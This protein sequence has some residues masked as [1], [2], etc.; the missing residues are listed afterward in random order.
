MNRQLL[1]NDDR[2]NFPA[3]LFGVHFPFRVEPHIY[4]TAG[5]LSAEYHGG[6]WLMY[7][8]EN[9]GFYMAPDDDAFR[10]SAENGYEGTMSGDAF[11]LTVCLY[12]F[13]EL[14]FSDIPGFVEVCAGQYHRLREY[15][16]EHPEVAA[17]LRAID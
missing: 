11:G 6:Y 3:K 4:V 10:V 2:I 17:I 5:R 13:S 9:G 7:R 8:L 1:N 16:F 14:S 12:A 15:M